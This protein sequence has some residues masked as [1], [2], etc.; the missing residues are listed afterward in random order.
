MTVVVPARSLELF[1]SF[2]PWGVTVS[3]GGGPMYACY[4]FD[5][6]VAFEGWGVLGIP[7]ALAVGCVFT[8]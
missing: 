4:A 6:R 1:E 2:L 7:K 5:A 8:A 3:G